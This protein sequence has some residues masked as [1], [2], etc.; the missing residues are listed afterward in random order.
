LERPARNV[1]G[2]RGQKAKVTTEVPIKNEINR[3]ETK[4]GRRTVERPIRK[5]DTLEDKATEERRLKNT[6]QK[7]VEKA[8]T[9]RIGNRAQDHS[10][11]KKAKN[12]HKKKKM[13]DNKW[14]VQTEHYF[15]RSDEEL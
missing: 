11:Q 3:P 13:K 6:T 14:L 9:K 10:A 12:Y 15:L 2:K 1:R 8:R 7:G 5:A 4:T